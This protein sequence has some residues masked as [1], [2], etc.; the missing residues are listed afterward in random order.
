[1]NT[2]KLKPMDFLVNVNRGQDPFSVIKR[3]AVGEYSHVSMYMGQMTIEV[4]DTDYFVDSVMLRHLMLFE[5]NGRG[6]AIQSLSNRYGQKVVVMRLNLQFRDKIPLIV[7][8]AIRLA[9]DPQAYYDYYCIPLNIIPRILH[10]KF[11][12]PLPVKYQRDEKMVCSEACAEVCWR[13]KVPVLP[14]NAVPLPGDFVE[15]SGILD[16]VNRGIL[17]EDWV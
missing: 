6:V 1:M 14:Q 16:E 17:S 2:F 11:G 3:W 9:S 10:D 15:L 8:E 4:E 7:E 12:M 5:S 13:A